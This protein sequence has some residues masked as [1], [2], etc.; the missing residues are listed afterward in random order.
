[1][2]EQNITRN[3]VGKNLE[4]GMSSKEVFLAELAE[5]SVFVYGES[6]CLEGQTR[7]FSMNRG[8]TASMSLN[9]SFFGDPH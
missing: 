6:N 8:A 9:I 7:F 3:L 4:P 2:T 1:M 5:Q